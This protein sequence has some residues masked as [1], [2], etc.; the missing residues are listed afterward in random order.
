MTDLPRRT[1]RLLT[2]T[3]FLVGLGLAVRAYHYFRN[4]P[5][6]HDEA[7]LV[8]NVLGKSFHDL[9]GPLFFAEAAPPLFLWVERALALALSDSTYVLRLLP[10]LAGSASLVLLVPVARRT[11]D[12]RAVPWA[13]FLLAWSD[14]LLW[15]IS[16]SKPYSVDVLVAVTVLFVY[17]KGR[18]WPA[19]RLIALYALLAPV[20]ILLSYPGTF[21]CGGVLLALLPGA[22]RSRSLRHWLMIG[23]LA[24]VV[25][26]T[27]LY[28]VTGPVR[29]QRVPLI[30]NCWSGE[31]PDWSK[32][33]GVPL[34]AVRATLDI[35]R[36]C[37]E[38]LG[39]VLIGVVLVGLVSLWRRQRT[40]AVL[41][42][43]PLALAL[44]ASLMGAYPYDGT[45]VM[46]YASPAVVLLL[47]E[48]AVRTL[49]WL[50]ARARP[51]AVVLVGM[52]IVPF[53]Y[54][55]VHVLRQG[56][57]P[58]CD[59]A[60][61][62]ILERLGPGDRV[63]SNAWECKYYFRRLGPA[64]STV[65]EI[66][67]VPVDRLW[68]VTVAATPE[69]RWEMAS[70]ETARGWRILNQQDFRR[71]TVYLMRRGAGPEAGEESEELG[72]ERKP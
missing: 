9:L 43:A 61:D 46:V 60:A 16:E 66:E 45:R 6:W 8:L 26:G 31:F 71:V 62:Y 19:M 10:F 34:W 35:V 50:W 5:M 40:F 17:C 54:A 15:H 69:V 72:P 47:G 67:Q 56:G 28:L 32:P 33:L 29:A 64:F 38:P 51:V 41:L 49:D 1:G 3:G 52:L 57:R 63:A 37:C 27:F 42:L 58:A 68:L 23:M 4:P 25:G 24:L 70:H 44:V 12:P 11:L 53:F 22:W 30:E 59:R 14:Q 48:G 65:E 20:A 39:N 55:G 21:V 7:A 2:S 13:V 36:Y 18:D